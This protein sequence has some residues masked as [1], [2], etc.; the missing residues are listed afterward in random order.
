MPD[1][2]RLSE[3]YRNKGLVI[4]A[5]SVGQDARTVRSF[6]Q[7]LRL[8]FPAVLDEDG[9]VSH[10]YGIRPIPASFLVGRDGAILWRAMGAREWDSAEVRQYLDRRLADPRRK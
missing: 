1:L 10:L 7:E 6:M 3:S 4:L 9:A 2:E 5:V 8:S